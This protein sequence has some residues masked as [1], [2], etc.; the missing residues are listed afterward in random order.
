M[1]ARTASK[2][3]PEDD[4]KDLEAEDTKAAPLRDQE[5]TNRTPAKT[6][7]EDTIRATLHRLATR[8][9]HS[10]HQTTIYYGLV[11]PDTPP[12][13]KYGLLA[14]SIGIV[15]LQCFVATG[16]VINIAFGKCSDNQ[17]CNGGMFCLDGHCFWCD[18]NLKGCCESNSTETNS[19]E[20]CWLNE[21][22]SQNMC[23][24]CIM[25]RGFTPYGK[26]T[27]ERVESMVTQDWRSPSN[28]DL[29]PL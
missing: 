8:E 1:A 6:P 17:D 25:E 15:F 21:E 24:K 11:R 19:T 23:S 7:D 12:R 10:F 20:S 27:M 29:E 3:S 14:A 16:L 4:A 28:E 2:V 13:R 26:A 22:S 5:T 9:P 18:N